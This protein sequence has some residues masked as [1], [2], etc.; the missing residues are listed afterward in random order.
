MCVYMCVWGVVLINK[1]VLQLAP[2]PKQKFLAPLLAN[3]IMQREI[4]CNPIAFLVLTTFLKKKKEFQPMISTSNDSSLSLD[5]DT[6]K[7]FWYR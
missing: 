3:A 1:L 4:S 2:P 6:N 5:Q 7:F